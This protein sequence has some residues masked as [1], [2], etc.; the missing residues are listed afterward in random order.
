M[1]K[2]INN[3]L[4]L[5]LFFLIN[6]L[7]MFNPLFFLFL[8]P[9]RIFS[10]ISIFVP[11][12]I[13]TYKQYLSL[14]LMIIMI[15]LLNICLEF[16]FYINIFSFNTKRDLIT[17]KFLYFISTNIYIFPICIGI[18]MFL[19]ISIPNNKKIN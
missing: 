13:K 10:Y 16:L 5:L 15:L 3:R 17:E 6:F 2:L 19:I 12:F 14:K 9:L 11:L 7:L 8:F 4:F 1:I 18:A